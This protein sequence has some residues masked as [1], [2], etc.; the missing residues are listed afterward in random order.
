M[1]VGACASC[2]HARRYGTTI[3]R[4]WAPNSEAPC[5]VSIRAECYVHD[6]RSCGAGATVKFWSRIPSWAGWMKGLGTASIAKTTHGQQWR[7][8]TWSEA[9]A[10]FPLRSPSSTMCT[11]E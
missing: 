8:A 6:G 3:L 7:R 2:K 10:S 5:A 9:A 1:E 4:R 11:S